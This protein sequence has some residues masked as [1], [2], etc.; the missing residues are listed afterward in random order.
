MEGKLKALFEYQRFE[1]NE[2]LEQL[3]R[4]AENNYERA[5]SDGELSLVNAAGELTPT[6]PKNK[7]L[8]DK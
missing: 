1:G 3:I 8:I 5:L 2:H 7:T 4:Q 6:Y